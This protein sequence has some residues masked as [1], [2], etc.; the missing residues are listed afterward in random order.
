MTN[1]QEIRDIEQRWARLISQRNE[2]YNMVLNTVAKEQ[3]TAVIEELNQSMNYEKRFEEMEEELRT[4]DP[5][6]IYLEENQL[7][8]YKSWN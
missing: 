4:L 3:Q 5:D 6:H 2:H 8:L 7:N 1:T